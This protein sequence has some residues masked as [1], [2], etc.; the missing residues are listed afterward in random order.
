MRN[1]A[2]DKLLSAYLD[3][4]LAQQDAQRVR[5]YLEDSEEAREEFR[6]LQELKKITSE[7]AFAPPPDD[8]LDELARSLSVQA[9][10][11]AGWIMI[12]IGVT[13]VVLAMVV[14][15]ATAPDVP[16]TVKA[17]YGAIGGGFLLLLGSVARQ[18]WL[19][20]PYDRYRG[21]KR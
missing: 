6:E 18:R 12:V 16:L 11:K 7:L 19:E 9:P 1:E 14:R 13:A 10:Q 2:L 5:I 8:R 17:V 15:L 20:A 4:E 21:V 3:G